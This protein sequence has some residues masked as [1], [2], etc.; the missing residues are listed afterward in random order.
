MKKFYCKV[1]VAVIIIVLLG[2]NSYVFAGG[3][4]AFSV[5]TDYGYFNI[6]T[7]Q[8]AIIASN[9]YRTAGY[10]SY[11]DITPNRTSLL[12]MGQQ[13]FLKLKSDILFFSGHGNQNGIYFQYKNNSPSDNVAIVRGTSNYIAN[14]GIYSIGIN[15]YM[16]TVKL[17]VFAG[18]KTAKD[19]D[20]IAK[21]MRDNG[22]DVSIGWGET[23]LAEQHSE[24][25]NRFNTKL[26]QGATIDTAVTYANSFGYTDSA[27]Y[28]VK[29]YVE[30]SNSMNQTIK[31]NTRTNELEDSSYQE[32]L[33]NQQIM[34]TSIE[35]SLNDIITQIV[36]IDPDFNIHDYN[37]NFFEMNEYAST[38]VF[39]KLI[40]NFE[41]NC[42]YIVHIRNGYVNK[43]VRNGFNEYSNNTF[44]NISLPDVSKIQELKERASQDCIE[45]TGCESISDQ[46]VKMFYDVNENKGYIIIMTQYIVG[47][48]YYGKYETRYEL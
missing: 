38:I 39:T 27:I 35:N 14:D 37:Y 44:S 10:T 36:Q 5:G 43:I 20:N 13:G 26:S 11:C 25:L 16:S 8:D 6:D 31:S 48:E 7:S 22:A 46:E 23:V 34:F 33:L 18:C 24:W 19:N 3:Q 42:N 17:A 1:M 32:V 45:K 21:T 47:S 29:V 40:N 12:Q 9:C 4:Q 41:T 15:N 2:N 28:T 30:N